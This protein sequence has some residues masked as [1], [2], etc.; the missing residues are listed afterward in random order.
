MVF[1]PDGRTAIANNH[2]WDVAAGRLLVVLQSPCST[3]AYSADGRRIITLDR[4]GVST[5]DVTTGDEL[6]RPIPIQWAGG[7]R[8]V[9]DPMAGSSPSDVSPRARPDAGTRATD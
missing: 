8:G 4:D 6:R 1:S 2:V 9:F 3:A 7:T 5:W